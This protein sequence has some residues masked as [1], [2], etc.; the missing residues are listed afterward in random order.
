MHIYMHA[1][2]STVHSA[3][4]LPRPPSGSTAARP[5][6]G[7]RPRRGRTASHTASLS[8]TQAL[9][10]GWHGAAQHRA[11][12]IPSRL[13]LEGKRAIPGRVEAAFSADEWAGLLQWLAARASR[14]RSAH[15]STLLHVSFEMNE[16]SSKFLVA[17]RAPI[18]TRQIH[19]PPSLRASPS[20]SRRVRHH[21]PAVRDGAERGAR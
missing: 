15:R 16:R 12:R 11:Y 21:V 10:S 19:R 6:G 5:R 17:V 9:V 20:P 8:G 13:D 7:P 1:Y 3:P 2:V 18:A 14:T 4:G